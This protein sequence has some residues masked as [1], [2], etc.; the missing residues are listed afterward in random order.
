EAF[1][2]QIALAQRRRAASALPAKP[3]PPVAGGLLDA[4]DARLP[5]EL[6]EGQRQVGREIAEDLAREHPMHRL[7]QGDVGAGKAQPLDAGVLTPAGFRPMG[8][9]AVGDEVVTPTGEVTVVTGVFPQGERDVYRVVFCDGTSV[10]CDDEHLWPVKT[11]DGWRQGGPLEVL[12][13]R[14]LRQELSKGNGAWCLPLI[15]PPQLDA[16]APRPVDPYLLGLLLGDGRA[17]NG[18]VRLPARDPEVIEAVAGL[19]PAGCRLQQEQDGPRDLLVLGERRRADNPLLAALRELGVHGTGGCD[20][21]VPDRYLVAPVKERHA[22][23]QGLLDSRGTLRAHGRELAFT[24]ASRRLAEDVAWLTRS[25]G[26][27]A[28]CRPVTDAGERRWT[29]SVAL[30]DDVESFRLSRK[31]GEL[32]DRLGGERRRKRIRSI[33]Y[34]GRKHVQCI[35]VAHPDRQYVTDGWT[36][37]HN[38]MVA[39]RAMLQVVDGGG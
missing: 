6:T 30:P 17:E 5:F 34:V 12:T 38:T 7:L 26:G 4:F 8:E 19:I 9:T 15:E 2:L 37:T 13:T 29:T 32:W 18:A 21:F 27:Y 25:L 20:R 31:V 35:S 23:L 36:P 1:V 24:S 28:R 22:L 14:E 11:D 16:V 10:E 33:E 39:L 3:R